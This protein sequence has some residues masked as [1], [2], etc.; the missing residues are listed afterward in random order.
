[1]PFTNLLS[2]RSWSLEGLAPPWSGDPLYAWIQANGGNADLPDRREGGE[3]K[4]GWIA[5]AV[6]GV[7]NHHGFEPDTLGTQQTRNEIVSAVK[8]LLSR[9]TSENLSAL[10]SLIRGEKLLS[11]V[12]EL[13]QS[14]SEKL[15]PRSKLRLAALGRFLATM[16]DERETV[17]FG[18]VLIGMSGDES[19]RAMLEL[20]ATHDEFT[21][22]AA[23][24]LSRVS[25]ILSR[26]FGVSLREFMGGAGF[27]LS[28][29]CA[30]R[31]IEKSRHG[32][33][34]MGSAI[35]S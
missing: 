2:F 21:L 26:R 13:E 15:M 24:A 17:K 9:S 10:Y 14:V 23:Q 18:I 27:K 32:C 31:R 16:G 28:S 4:I 20:L 34:A 8:K 33:C 6:D 12:G 11:E 29:C 35:M 30:E 1:M 3:N 22:Y 25:Q 19:E 5:G 7:M